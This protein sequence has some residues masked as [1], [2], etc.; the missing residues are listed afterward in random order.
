MKSI[1]VFW[2][3]YS[4]QDKGKL[5]EC[6]LQDGKKLPVR[7]ENKEDKFELQVNLWNCRVKDLQSTLLFPFLAIDFGVI[8]PIKTKQLAFL[9]PFKVEKDKF[10][11]LADILFHHSELLCSIFNENLGISKRFNDNYYCIDGDRKLLMYELSVDNIIEMN[12]DDA[13][14]ATLI[15]FSINSDFLEDNSERR[16]FLRFRFSLDNLDCF[17]IK[18]RISNDW[19]QSAFSST[20]LF[21]I[22][23]NDA[24]ELSKKKIELLEMHNYHF[25]KFKKV[26]FLYMADATESIESDNSVS[27]DSRLLEKDRWTPYLGENL[28]FTSENIAHHW[29]LKE[30]KSIGIARSILHDG[31]LDVKYVP[32]TKP[33]SSFTLF[34]KTIFSEL[35]TNRIALYS[36]IVILLGILSSA[37]VTI[38]SYAIADSNISPIVLAIV[39]LFLLSAIV[40]Y[41]YFSYKELKA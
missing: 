39:C 29:K 23:I 34:Y 24:R 4:Q 26:H 37:I 38:V 11:D 3:E 10:V 1:G 31:K 22:R 19:L 7:V 41:L 28:Q 12:Y 17:A 6:P 15:R 27:K 14:N 5:K 21:D 13:N 25:P 33:F 16:L 30:S 32:I 40:L 8:C 9:L 20:Y 36:I 18:K 35:E 2:S